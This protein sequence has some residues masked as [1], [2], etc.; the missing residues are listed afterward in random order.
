MSGGE[1]YGLNYSTAYFVNPVDRKSL[2]GRL[3]FE[4]TDSLNIFSE[5]GWSETHSKNR[6]A[7]PRDTAGFTVRIDNPYLPAHVRNLMVQNNLTT[8][9]VGRSSFDLGNTENDVVTTPSRF[10]V[11]AQ[12]LF[13]GGVWDWDAFAQ[14]GFTDYQGDIENARMTARWNSSIDV[15]AGPNGPVCRNNPY[16]DCVPANIFGDG[17]ISE[18]AK[19][20]F[21]GRELFDLKYKQLVYAFNARGAPFSTPAGDI[22]MAAGVEHRREDSQGV[23][24]PVSQIGGWNIGNQRSIDGKFDNSEAYFEVV[25]PLLA[26]RAFAERLELDTAVRVTDY[27]T[28]GTVETWKVGL[29]YQ[30]TDPVRFRATRSRDIRAANISEL[31][32]QGVSSN[33]RIDN[34]VTGASNITPNVLIGNPNL[35]PEVAD[36]LTFGVVFQPS[37]A[38]NL[39]IS[40]DRYDIDL[41]DAITSVSG[42]RIVDLCLREGQQEYCQYITFQG[43]LITAVTRPS[44]NIAA[45]K[46]DGYD[47]EVRYVLPFDRF[48]PSAT[49]DLTLQL[50]ASNVGEMLVDDGTGP[51]IDRAGEVGS[52]GTNAYGQ[53]EWKSNFVVSYHKD[54][55][56]ITAIT[57]YI[58][59][60][61]YDITYTPNDINDN[62]I[63][64]AVYTNL[65]GQ[66]TF[67]GSDGRSMQIYGA[68]DNVFDQDP[69]V[70]PTNVS[71]TNHAI[72][73]ILGRMYKFGF[74]YNF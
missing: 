16:N 9:T 7:Q 61:A 65:S 23:A 57:R 47:V 26:G 69:P 34:P 31:F 19:D 14:Y 35:L 21:M 62:E 37:F 4:A 24:D 32:A 39:D 70:S 1:G 67:E 52:N 45:V 15:V 74:K 36:T 50:L 22:A 49:G 18:A 40:I 43:D 17:S 3:D 53:A 44:I 64:N 28:S 41:T 29:N 63:E 8:L 48:S 46:T 72:Y 12:G 27:S 68:I 6:G 71:S 51:I 33:V 11:G 25:T 56:R 66:Y 58:S 42:Q 10:V 59:S 13:P 55:F 5:V 60:G 2:I 73:D 30:I 20:Y 54:S 38:P